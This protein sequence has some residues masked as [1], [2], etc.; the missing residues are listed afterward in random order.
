MWSTSGNLS[1]SIWSA[2]TGFVDSSVFGLSELYEINNTGMIVGKRIS[3]G[4]LVIRYADG[5]MSVLQRMSEQSLI[6]DMNDLGWVVGYSSGGEGQ[7]A[8]LWKPISEPSS[9]LALLCGISGMSGIAWR[10]RK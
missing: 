4:K 9:I 7:H 10:R 2:D 3:D 5:S 8:L 6:C 1:Y